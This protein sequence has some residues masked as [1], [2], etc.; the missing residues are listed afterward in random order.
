M[1]AY[2]RLES[3]TIQPLILEG[4]VKKIMGKHTCKV[5]NEEIMSDEAYEIHR[6]R[7]DIGSKLQKILETLET[8]TP[9]SKSD[10]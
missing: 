1:K 2:F 7:H 4:V 8:M 5:C 10:I 6:L 3:K 9:K